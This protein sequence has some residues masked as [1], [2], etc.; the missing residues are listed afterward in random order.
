MYALPYAKDI[1]RVH[2]IPMGGFMAKMRLRREQQLECYVRW[3]GRGGEEL[4]RLIVV[5]VYRCTEGVPAILVESVVIISFRGPI[6]EEVLG[7][8]GAIVDLGDI[9]GSLVLDF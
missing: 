1:A 2:G 3:E 5:W 4:M 9:S 8:V 6:F 7:G